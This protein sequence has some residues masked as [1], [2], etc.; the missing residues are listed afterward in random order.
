MSLK[1][2][3]HG[4]TGRL[5][6]GLIAQAMIALSILVLPAGTASADSQAQ[7]GAFA[8]IYLTGPGADSCLPKDEK[9]ELTYDCKEIKRN[10]IGSNVILHLDKK[11]FNV[12][13]ELA[14]N[15]QDPRQGLN[16]YEQESTQKVPYVYKFGTIKARESA[17]ING[18]NVTRQDDWNLGLDKT[19]GT[20]IGLPNYVGVLITI[21]LI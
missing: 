18:Q 20:T 6:L 16:W 21:T 13:L 10:F 15:S 8:D 2:F 11:K 17:N 12:H 3:S 9:T 14:K 1:L 4:V 5:L 19:F 7:T